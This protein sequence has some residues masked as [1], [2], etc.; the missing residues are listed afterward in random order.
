MSMPDRIR[1]EQVAALAQLADL[2][3][4]PDR[5]AGVAEVLGS[6]IPAANEL[7]AAMSAPE[8]SR[9]V[10]IVSFLGLS[11]DGVEHSARQ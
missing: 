1:P 11:V 10:P 8:H 4:A 6:W 7:S 9:L 3:L 2:P 5:L